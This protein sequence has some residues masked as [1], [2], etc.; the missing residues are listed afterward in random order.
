M[1]RHGTGSVIVLWAWS[2]RMTV[3]SSSANHSNNQALR[4]A[5][6]TKSLARLVGDLWVEG[7][8]KS[9]V[10][11]HLLLRV[12]GFQVDSKPCANVRIFT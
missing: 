4:I 8:C 7:S 10:P 11:L 12:I 3:D 6:L 1:V 2:T 5:C 9:D